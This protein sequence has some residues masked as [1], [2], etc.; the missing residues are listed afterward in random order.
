[1]AEPPA[2]TRPR[3]CEITRVIAQPCTPA[4]TCTYLGG[5]GRA[6]GSFSMCRTSLGSRSA[7]ASRGDLAGESFSPQ[8]HEHQVAAEH[9]HAFTTHAGPCRTWPPQPHRWA[10]PPLPPRR[11]LLRATVCFSTHLWDRAFTPVTARARAS[12]VSALASSLRR[13]AFL[14]PARRAE[15]RFHRRVGDLGVNPAPFFALA[16]P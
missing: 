7:T 5:Q 8:G 16:T 13:R 4:R 2:C 12:R 6:F 15:Q 1:V 14:C 9:E 10:A 3:A 11:A